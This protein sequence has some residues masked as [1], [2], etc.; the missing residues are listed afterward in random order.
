MAISVVEQRLEVAK[1]A[2]SLS[3][4]SG[5]GFGPP[6]CRISLVFKLEDMFSAYYFQW[7][8]RYSHHPVRYV[9]LGQIKRGTT[10][11]EVTDFLI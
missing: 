11:T 10:V 7:R 1:A 8:G 4:A 5:G 6:F 3:P 2:Q 9:T